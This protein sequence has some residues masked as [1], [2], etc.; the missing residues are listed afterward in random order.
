MGK[1]QYSG[2]AKNDLEQIGDYIAS[3]LKSPKAAL[4]TVRKI[5]NS[6]DRLSSFPYIGSP[7]SG[8]VST[9]TDYRLLVCGKYLAFYR[10][11]GSDVMIDR[12]L[13]GK[14][15]YMNVLFGNILV[16]D[17]EQKNQE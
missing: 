10:L 16:D 9:T 3:E 2:V 15:D 6:I 11:Y 4:N 1:V 7:L 17:N 5:Q 12:I 13:Y 8:L 14:R